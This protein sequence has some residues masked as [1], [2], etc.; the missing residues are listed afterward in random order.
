MLIISGAVYGSHSFLRC[1]IVLT[2]LDSPKSHSFTREKSERKTKMLSSFTSR[3]QISLFNK[4]MDK[5][6][7]SGEKFMNLKGFWDITLN[8]YTQEQLRFVSPR[9]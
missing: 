4:K 7:A 8:A 3:W 6:I 5:K 1:T 9:V 2:F